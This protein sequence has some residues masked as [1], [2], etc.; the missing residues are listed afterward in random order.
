MRC[1]FASVWLT[2][3]ANKYSSEKK[4][5]F[6]ALISVS[7]VCPA[8]DWQAIGRSATRLFSNSPVKSSQTWN[9]G[10]AEFVTSKSP[11]TP[12][13]HPVLDLF[14]ILMASKKQ[15]LSVLFEAESNEGVN[16]AVWHLVRP[17]NRLIICKFVLVLKHTQDSNSLGKILTT[18]VLPSNL[19]GDF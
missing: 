19:Q 5:N 16:I 17:Q 6:K 3:A 7:W 9:C 10:F 15:L 4:R 12:L 11:T 13:P 14:S 1:R 2:M 8:R 18:A